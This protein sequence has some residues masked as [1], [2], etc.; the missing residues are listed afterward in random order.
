M[1]DA[2]ETSGLTQNKCTAALEATSFVGTKETLFSLFPEQLD[3]AVKRI[4]FALNTASLWSCIL[5]TAVQR[6]M[7]A[8]NTA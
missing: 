3:A 5:H 6:I 4:A 2:P 8:P 7:L 1:R